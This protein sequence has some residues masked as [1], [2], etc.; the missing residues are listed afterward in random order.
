MSDDPNK[1]ALNMMPYGFYS[2]T[3]RDGDE[4][5]AMVANWITQASFEPRLIAMG[6]QKS[7]Y[8]YGMS[9]ITIY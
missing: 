4:V 1:D 6:L 3:S 7:A 5:N 8:T 2:V 9:E